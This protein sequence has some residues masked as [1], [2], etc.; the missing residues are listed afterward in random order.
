MAKAE[1]IFSRAFVCIAAINL[2][3]TIC[4]QGITTAMPVYIASLGGDGVAMG[5]STTVV[6]ASALV[7]RAFIGPILDRFG[8]K[9]ALIASTV[10]TSIAVCMYALF[11]TVAIVLLFRALNGVGLALGTTAASTMAA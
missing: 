2:F 11:P 6:T 4:F 3:F 1:A 9:G 7:I 8:C 10:I 5:L